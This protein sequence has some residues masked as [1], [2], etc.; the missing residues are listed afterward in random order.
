[1]QSTAACT[2]WAAR[3]HCHDWGWDGTRD[4]TRDGWD[5]CSV[6]RRGSL[7]KEHLSREQRAAKGHAVQ[8]WRDGRR[9]SCAAGS[10]GPS[11]APALCDCFPFPWEPVEPCARPPGH[12][13]SRAQ[14]H[15]S[16]AAAHHQLRADRHCTAPRLKPSPSRLP[17]TPNANW[18]RLG[19]LL[20]PHQWPIAAL[21][22]LI[23]LLCLSLYVP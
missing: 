1:M 10:A 8:T 6:G 14:A 18:G 5:G 7:D 11:T 16:R 15:G 21:I 13:C 22:V 3:S 20:P 2:A 19:Q 17:G 4:R 12:E 9:S 23:H